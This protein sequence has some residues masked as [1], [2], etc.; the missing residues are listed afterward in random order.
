MRDYLVALVFLAG[1]AASVL[2]PETGSEWMGLV[3]VR[4]LGS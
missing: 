2:Q 1:F 4:L 3:G